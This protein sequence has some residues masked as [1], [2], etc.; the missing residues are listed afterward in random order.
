MSHLLSQSSHAH[1]IAEGGQAIASR[2]RHVCRLH[3]RGKVKVKKEMKGV[4][5]MKRGT[6]YIHELEKLSVF[7]RM[8]ERQ[9]EMVQVYYRKSETKYGFG[10]KRVCVCVSER[11]KERVNISCVAA[12]AVTLQAWPD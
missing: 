4:Y 10:K 7:V 9:K 11:R 1:D 5:H 3:V 8:R 2:G 12:C 6:I